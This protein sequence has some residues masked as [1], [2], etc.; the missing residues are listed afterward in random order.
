MQPISFSAKYF[1]LDVGPEFRAQITR[2]IE[3]ELHGALLKSQAGRI[4]PVRVPQ[5]GQ[6]GCAVS[7]ADSP[8]GH[9]LAARVGAREEG[10]SQ[11]M[12]G[13]GQEARAER[14]IIARVLV[15]RRIQ[16]ER[17]HAVDPRRG[18]LGSEPLSVSR[19]ALSPLSGKVYVLQKSRIR[20]DTDD[21]SGTERLVGM[22][23]Q[24]VLPGQDVGALSEAGGRQREDGK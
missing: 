17:Q 7:A 19:T 8:G 15:Q 24:L 5:V 2:E 20:G 11:R 23:A 9:S 1:P 14:A 16:T 18:G 21:G 3:P 10:R 12:S 13:A 22:K 4:E 6:E